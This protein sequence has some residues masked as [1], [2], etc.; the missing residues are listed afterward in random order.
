M[1]A[2]TPEQ[3]AKLPKWAQDHISKLESERF[4]SVR[5]LNEFCDA[6]TKS[7]IYFD[8]LVCTGERTGPSAKRKYVQTNKIEVE[9]AGLQLSVHLS[10]RDDSQ[11]SFGIQLQWSTLKRM[12]SHVAAMPTAFNTL[13]LVAKENM[14]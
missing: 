9:H 3:I 1:S 11:R 2:P 7:G 12:C 6:Q 14:R 4:V 10:R 8:D 5:T 13:E